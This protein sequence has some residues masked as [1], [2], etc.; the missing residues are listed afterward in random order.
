[1]CQRVHCCGSCQC[2]TWSLVCRFLSLLTYFSHF[3]SLKLNHESQSVFFQARWL[4]QPT[5]PWSTITTCSQVRSFFEEEKYLKCLNLTNW[6][7]K[8]NNFF[9][10]SANPSARVHLRRWTFSPYLWNELLWMNLSQE[11]FLP[12]LTWTCFC[13]NWWSLEEIWIVVC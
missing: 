10:D 11:Y 9:A 5:C 2:P 12:T 4:Q 8:L 1:M 6:K 7:S 3:T 13:L